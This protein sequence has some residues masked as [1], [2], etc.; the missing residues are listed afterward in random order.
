[1][2]HRSPHRAVRGIRAT[3]RSSQR[4]AVPDFEALVFG[5][6]H[7]VGEDLGAHLVAAGR[8]E[9]EG[10]ASVVIEDSRFRN[11][12]SGTPSNDI[13]SAATRSLSAAARARASRVT[14]RTSQI[15]RNSIRMLQ[16][17]KMFR[18]CALQQEP[19]SPSPLINYVTRIGGERGFKEPF[20]RRRCVSRP[21]S[22]TPRSSPMSVTVHACAVALR[23]GRARTRDLRAHDRLPLPQ[24]SQ[25]LCR[26]A[27]QAR[28]RARAMPT[29]RSKNRARRAGDGPKTKRR[30]STMP[31]R[32]GTTIS[33]G[34]RCRRRRGET[35]G[36]LAQAIERDFG[37][38]D[39]AAREARRSRQG[40]V[41]LR[42]GVAGVERRQALRR[43]DRQCGRTHGAGRQLPARRRRVGARLLSRLPERAAEISGGG[44]DKVLNWDFAA[45][46]LDK[47]DHAVRAAAE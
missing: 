4:L 6:L 26:D 20:E 12:A 36:K 43:E 9:F 23:R 21:S 47:E 16:L 45:E 14:I 41:R 35:G 33:T 40:A 31:P 24:A 13:A 3:G 42:L 44:A 19:T 39:N 17:H 27:E 22:K 18:R 46:N 37:G 10:E 2:Q 11:S 7:R 34:A 25:D 28:R 32:C 38:V 5:L 15:S 1:M 8:G 29:C 30:S